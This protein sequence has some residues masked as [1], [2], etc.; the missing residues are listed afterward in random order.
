MRGG[1]V[2]QQDRDIA[3]AVLR[4]WEVAVMAASPAS[5]RRRLRGLAAIQRNRSVRACHN[6]DNRRTDTVL[7]CGRGC[8]AS[9]CAPTGTPA[10]LGARQPPRRGQSGFVRC[11]AL[12]HRYASASGVSLGLSVHGSR[13]SI[14]KP[15][16]VPASSYPRDDKRDPTGRSVDDLVISRASHSRGWRNGLGG[17][18]RSARRPAVR[19]RSPA[20]SMRSV[21]ASYRYLRPGGVRVPRDLRTFTM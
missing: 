1:P 7:G 18:C 16:N 11:H 9:D 4:R 2:D 19:R 6:L 14:H 13:S 8:T 3:T 5:C 20:V 10:A 21:H 12:I 15:Q 17:S